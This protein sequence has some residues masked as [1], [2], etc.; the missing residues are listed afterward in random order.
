MASIVAV[1]ATVAAIARAPS[2]DHRSDPGATTTDRSTG[3][4]CAPPATA[5]TGRA[6]EYRRKS[7][8]THVYVR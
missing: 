8:E 1:A 6:D 2:G 7:L 4:P 5:S 3:S